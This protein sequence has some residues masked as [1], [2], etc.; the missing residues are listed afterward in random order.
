MLLPLS[1]VDTGAALS[2]DARGRE[3]PV[4]EA[5]IG[6]LMRF[7]FGVAYFWSGVYKL[8][9]AAWTDGSAVKLALANPAWRRF[10]LGWLLSWSWFDG[11]ISVF[12]L[13][14]P[15]WSFSF[16]CWFLWA[17]FAGSVWGSGSFST[18]LNF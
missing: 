12:S 13:I 8:M 15:W 11:F 6:R 7:Q 17:L 18:G 1:F 9:G 4:I 5:W 10:D 14:T 3:P 16:H 2:L